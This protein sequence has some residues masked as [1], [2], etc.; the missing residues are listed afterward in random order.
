VDAERQVLRRSLR[1]LLRDEIAHNQ[2][3]LRE[4]QTYLDAPEPD[5]RELTERDRYKRLLDRP[6]QI[7]S[8]MWEGQAQHLGV[9]LD[10]NENVPTGRFHGALQALVSQWMAMQTFSRKREARLAPFHGVVQG[11]DMMSVNSVLTEYETDMRQEYTR[12]T[13]A[14][15]TLIDTPNPI[16]PDD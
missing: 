15:Q 16:G 8:A 13:E 6:L 10:A 3:H 14:L 11:I 12:F 7:W 5:S 9:V 2:E 1:A 4:Y